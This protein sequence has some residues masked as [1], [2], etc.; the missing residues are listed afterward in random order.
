MK[1]LTNNNVYSI[2]EI[3]SQGLKKQDIKDLDYAVF[4]KDNKVYF[5]EEV[6][7][8]S[9]RLFTIIREESFFLK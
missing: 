1:S 9:Y 3:N 6:N 7:N 5:F 8:K 4:Q 2:D